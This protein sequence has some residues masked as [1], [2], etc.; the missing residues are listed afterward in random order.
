MVWAPLITESITG[1]VAAG[2]VVITTEVVV[3]AVVATVVDDVVVVVAAVVVDD[4]AVALTISIFISIFAHKFPS[5]TKFSLDR[6]PISRGPV[7]L[8]KRVPFEE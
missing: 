3:V 2:V 7:V 4:V 6:R 5:E 8:S 1:V